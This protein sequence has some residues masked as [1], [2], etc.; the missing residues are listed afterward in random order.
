MCFKETI[1]L[2]NKGEI[3]GYY[4]YQNYLNFKNFINELNKSYLSNITDF[5]NQLY[6][7][8]TDGINVWS[9]LET[10]IKKN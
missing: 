3:L 5:S 9:D 4:F 8:L 1:D 10:H 6:P 7:S 2:N